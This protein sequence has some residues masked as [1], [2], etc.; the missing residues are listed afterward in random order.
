[1]KLPEPTTQEILDKII[2][3]MQPQMQQV[4]RTST[5]TGLTT[6]GLLSALI[7][8]GV[9]WD[10]ISPWW[11]IASTVLAIMAMGQEAKWWNRKG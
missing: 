3:S 8:A 10:Q 9:I 5:D 7:T 6:V 2:S 4:H 1:M 11:L